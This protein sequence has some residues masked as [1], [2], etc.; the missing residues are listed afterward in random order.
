MRLVKKIEIVCMNYGG[1]N[2]VTD[3]GPWATDITPELALRRLLEN[4]PVEEYRLAKDARQEPIDAQA[5]TD[6]SLQN[7]Q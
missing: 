2:A 5:A 4:L 7:R 6:T 1:W 3:A